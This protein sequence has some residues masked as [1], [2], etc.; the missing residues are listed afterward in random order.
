[1]G[2]ETIAIAGLVLGVGAAA[3]NADQ[4]RSAANKQNDALE[5][6]KKE[7]IKQAGINKQIADIKNVRE[8]RAL[9]RRSRVQAAAIE[10]YSANHGTSGST[11][12]IG[13]E[14]SLSTQTTGELGY[15]GQVSD[16]Q[17]KLYAS[18]TAQIGAARSGASDQARIATVGAIGNL[19]GTVFSGAGGFKTIFGGNK[20]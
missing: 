1:M 3:Y 14:A 13:A 16:A 17:D 10:N 12:S 11:G 7:S 8:Q 18:Q 20:P 6:Q 2:I 19:A 4:Q 15:F 5:T 9:I